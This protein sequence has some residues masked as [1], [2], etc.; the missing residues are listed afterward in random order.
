M[1]RRPGPASRLAGPAAERMLLSQSR[2]LATRRRVVILG[3]GWAGN[4]LAR[5]LNK[6]MCAAAQASRLR[7]ASAVGGR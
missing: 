6:E 5:G 2:G 1:L 3:S 4:K 7:Q